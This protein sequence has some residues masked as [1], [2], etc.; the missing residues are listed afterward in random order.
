VLGLR[1]QQL[2]VS[3]GGVRLLC[4]SHLGGIGHSELYQLLEAVSS[5]QQHGA[6]G[7]GSELWGLCRRVR[8]AGNKGLLYVRE[9]QWK[10]RRELLQQF[11]E[12]LLCLWLDYPLLFR[13]PGR[14][15]LR[16]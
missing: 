3:R 7:S 6:G 11:G 14:A 8:A 16:V 5:W 10:V 15:V 4:L 9:E 2:H 1:F 12:R 13:G